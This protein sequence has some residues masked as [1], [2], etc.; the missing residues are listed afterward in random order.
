MEH[1]TPDEIA[2]LTQAVAMNKKEDCP[3]KQIV[4]QQGI[5]ICLDGGMESRQLKDFK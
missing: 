3:H 5:Y 1:M 2:H 4:D